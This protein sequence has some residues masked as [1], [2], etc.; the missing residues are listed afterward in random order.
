MLAEEVISQPHNYSI[1]SARESLIISLDGFNS[2]MQTYRV[3]GQ[4]IPSSYQVGG[5]AM[6]SDE[7]L[8]FVEA[9]YLPP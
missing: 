2:A 1:S 3:E 8:E 9:P 4:P 7:P 6:Q 5:T